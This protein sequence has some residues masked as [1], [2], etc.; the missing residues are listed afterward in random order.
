[1]IDINK[2]LTKDSV[3]EERDL[4]AK[5]RN[6]LACERTLLAWM[7]TSLACMG[8]GFAIVRLIDFHTYTHLLI[9]TFTGVF[10]IFLSIA[11]LL[12]A[13]LNYKKNV[14]RLEINLGYSISLSGTSVIVLGLIVVAFLLLFLSLN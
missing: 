2:T 6:I 8:G 9:A 12:F 10:L 5:E 1:M 14:K 7:R 13:Y 11:I 3:M 4:L